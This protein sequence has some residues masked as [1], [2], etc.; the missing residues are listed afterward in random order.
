MV[1]ELGHFSLILSFSLGLIAL[2]LFFKKKEAFLPYAAMTQ[3]GLI[4]FSFFCLILAFLRSDFS[5]KSVAMH[6]HSTTPIV[7]KIAAA[8]GHHEGSMLLWCFFLSLIIAFFSTNKQKIESST[9]QSACVVLQS[10]LTL[11]LAYS[12][13]TSNPFERLMPFPINRGE[14]NPLLQDPSLTFH[15]LLLYMGFLSFSVPFALSVA[16]GIYPINHT[17]FI[18]WSR[19]WIAA[20]WGFLTLGILTGSIWAYYELGWGGWWFWD[21][22]ESAS[23]LPWLVAA[24]LVHFYKKQSPSKFLVFLT[25]LGFLLCLASVWVIRGGALLSVHTFA[26]SP[27]RSF[28]LLTIFCLCL[29]ISI[30]SAIRPLKDQKGTRSFFLDSA[31][32]TFLYL[33]FVVLWGIFFPILFEKATGQSVTMGS[34]YFTK[35]FCYPMLLMFLFMGFGPFFSKTAL[36][37]SASI[38]FIGVYC[39]WPQGLGLSIATGLSVWL[40]SWTVLYGFKNFHKKSLPLLGAHLGIGI[41]AL[42]ISVNGFLQKETMAVMEPGESLE[43]PLGILTFEGVKPI[44]RQNHLAYQGAFSV[45]TNN[46][47]SCIFNPERRLYFATQGEHSEATLCHHQLTTYSLILGET[48]DHQHWVVRFYENPFIILI[49]IGGILVAL[50]IFLLCFQKRLFIVFGLSLLWGTSSEAL[51]VYH[52]KAVALF[53]KIPCPTCP[54]QSLESAQ[55]ELSQEIRGVIDQEV[56]KGKSNEEIFKILENRFQI[57]VNS[58][59]PLW[60]LWLIPFCALG[61]LLLIFYRRKR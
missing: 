20:A 2:V 50:S 45:K 10:I 60:S 52:P 1:T 59:F 42:G 16:T 7:Y 56:Q 23:L 24:A 34:P 37:I 54:G 39:T 36:I 33:L 12:I 47:L 49:W 17:L 29:G 8:W 13:F 6:S 53:K 25:S 9:H 44:P 61:V 11:F 38:A 3:L 31:V 19:P 55:T 43:L 48:N 4:G 30:F 46:Q 27:N 58:S 22:V 18:Q 26:L 32:F 41:L 28:F 51:V 5:V 40:I 35:L 57:K 14:L 15:P 21:P